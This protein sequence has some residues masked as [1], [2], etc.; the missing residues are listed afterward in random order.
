MKLLLTK[1]LITIT[2]LKLA[3]T[4]RFIIHFMGGTEIINLGPVKKEIWIIYKDEMVEEEERNPCLLKVIS[5]AHTLEYFSYMYL[6]KV[7]VEFTC[8]DGNSF[9]SIM[10]LKTAKSIFDYI[11]KNYNFKLVRLTISDFVRKPVVKKDPKGKDVKVRNV[12]KMRYNKGFRMLGNL[13]SQVKQLEDFSDKYDDNS[14]KI[15]AALA[16]AFV[17]DVTAVDFI[18][19][20][21][22]DERLKPV[23]ENLNDKM[24][25][26]RMK[27]F[28]NLFKNDKKDEL[29]FDDFEGSQKRKVTIKEFKEALGSFRKTN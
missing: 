2:I 5:V 25:G 22:P 26:N 8:A 29:G 15:F 17:I 6:K 19:S 18:L 9:K 11:N 4:K 23:L 13:Q 12:N 16:R 14:R 1:L 28:D 20:R 7:F 21:E 3:T 24:M 10:N 27:L